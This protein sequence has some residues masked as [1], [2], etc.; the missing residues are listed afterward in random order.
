MLS[1]FYIANIRGEKLTALFSAKYFVTM[2]R[3]CLGLSL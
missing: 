2:H 3:T 1:S